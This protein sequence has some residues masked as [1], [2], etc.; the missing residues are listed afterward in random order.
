MVQIETTHSITAADGF[1]EAEGY[2]EQF[3]AEVRW[4]AWR[5]PG[6]VRWSAR[7]AQGEDRD[8]VLIAG[9]DEVL[10]AVAGWL[11]ER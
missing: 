5:N 11:G 4:T 3:G 8:L 6:D 1:R 10:R 9:E 7:T 2:A